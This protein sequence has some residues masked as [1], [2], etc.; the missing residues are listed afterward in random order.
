M[1]LAEETTSI[2]DNG[3]FA[4]FLAFIILFVIGVI[5]G[6]LLVWAGK[7]FHVEEDPRIKEVESRLPNANCGNCGYPGCHELAEAIVKGEVTK[8]SKCKVGNAEKNFKPIIA[9]LEEH[10]DKDGTKHVPTL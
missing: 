5:L 3:W 8:L 7:V 1:I 2:L 4:A 6:V 10:P 9:Y